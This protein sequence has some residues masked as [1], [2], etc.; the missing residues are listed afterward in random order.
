MDREYFHSIYFREPNGIL[1]EIAT[2]GPGFTIDEPVESLGENLKLPKQYEAHR[3]EIE[4]A[5]PPI[6]QIK[7]RVQERSHG[8]FTHNWRLLAWSAATSTAGTPLR[9]NSWTYLCFELS[10]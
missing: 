3:N 8:E 4:K 2:E 5:L 7:F 10:L 6:T 1:F 9:S